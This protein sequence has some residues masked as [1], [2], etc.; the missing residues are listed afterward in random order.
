MCW[1]NEARAEDLGVGVRAAH[2][3]DLRAFSE[4]GVIDATAAAPQALRVSGL[5]LTCQ[6]EWVL[7]RLLIGEQMSSSYHI[8]YFSVAGIK[9]HGQGNLNIEDFIW[10]PAPERQESI[11]S[12]E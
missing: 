5:S 4:D 2:S 10:L 11:T 6:A 7:V 1:D 9:H 12:G 3:T 8:G